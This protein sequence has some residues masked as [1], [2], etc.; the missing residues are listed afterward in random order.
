M[1][2]LFV[3]VVVVVVRP[4]TT[5]YEASVLEIPRLQSWLVVPSFSVVVWVVWVVWAMESLVVVLLLG[6]LWS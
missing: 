4:T 1:M 3:V 2:V 6:L 5:W